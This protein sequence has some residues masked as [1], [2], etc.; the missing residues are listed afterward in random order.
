MFIEH[1]ER[2]TGAALHGR[3][4]AWGG[5]GR[6]VEYVRFAVVFFFFS[7]SKM[8]TKSMNNVYKIRPEHTLVSLSSMHRF[9]PQKAQRSIRIPVHFWSRFWK[10]NRPW[11]PKGRP[12][13]DFELLREVPFASFFCD[14]FYDRLRIDVPA[15]RGSPWRSFSWFS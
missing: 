2:G 8:V 1:A 4:S 14:E 15:S 10:E 12:W 5:L 11:S 13:I 7:F 6:F 9:R 3:R